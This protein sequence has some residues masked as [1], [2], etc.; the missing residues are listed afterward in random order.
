MVNIAIQNIHHL[1]LKNDVTINNYVMDM[2]NE[3]YIKYLYF[4]DYNFMDSYN[5]PT[6]KKVKEMLEIYSPSDLGLDKTK[7]ILS[8][9]ALQKNCD[10]LLNFNVTKASEFTKGVKE[11][12]GLKIFHLMDYF[13]IEPGSVKCE[14]LKEFGINYVMSFS[15]SDKHCSYFQKYFQDYKNKVIPVPFGYQERFINEVPFENRIH[16]CVALGSV[17]PLNRPES[18]L[19][20]WKETAMFYPDEVWMHKFRRLLVNEKVSLTQI[21]DSLLAEFPKIQD[22]NYDIVDKFNQYQMFV[23]CESIFFFPPAKTFEGT[24]SGSVLICSDH[25]C[26]SEYGFIDGVNCIKHRQMD[27]ND[28]R[29]KVSYYI[30]HQ[31][32]LSEIQKS[33]T[34]FVRECYSHQVIAHKLYYILEMLHNGKTPDCPKIWA[35][36][37]AK[38]NTEK[39]NAM[40]EKDK[41]RVIYR[42]QAS[43]K[44]YIFMCKY[45]GLINTILQKTRQ[46]GSNVFRNIKRIVDYVKKNI[47]K[48]VLNEK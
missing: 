10:I 35:T 45:Y 25:P 7:V 18:P 17:N 33:G 11:F 22:W 5:T 30:N 28:F 12:K 3:G 1:F 46:R 36:K 42:N 21:M 2:I 20:N 24:A 44:R 31:K 39:E 19:N 29:K 6:Y 38:I 48:E 37:M 40:K 9:K 26:F 32:E 27:V 4:D 47:D 15:S 43:L 23:S 14:R 16:K 8:S 13:W 41:S 34:E